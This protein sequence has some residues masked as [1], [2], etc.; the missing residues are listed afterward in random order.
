LKQKG[1]SSCLLLAAGLLISSCRPAGSSGRID[2]DQVQ[3]QVGTGG[4]RELGRWNRILVSARATGGTFQGEVEVSGISLDGDR[5][6]ET[7]RKRFEVSRE[8]Q[9]V[10]IPFLPRDW[11][12][13]EVSFHGAGILPERLKA[14]VEWPVTPKYR[15][16][17]VR[18]GPPTISSLAQ[19]AGTWLA[20]ENRDDLVLG[21]ISPRELPQNFLG[22]QVADLV[23]LDGTALAGADPD[24]LES[25]LRW[26]RRGGTIAAI[27]GP[28]WTGKLPRRVRELF[29]IASPLEPVA[30]PKKFSPTLAAKLGGPEGGTLYSMTPLPGARYLHPGI[31]LENRYGSGTAFLCSLAPRGE[32]LRKFPLEP[33]V[34]SGAWR[35]IVKRGA[36]LRV[37]A[38]PLGE[39]EG[40]AVQTLV[41]FSGFRFPPRSKVAIFILCYLG[42]GFLLAGAFF[43]RKKRLEWMYLFSLVLAVLAS[44]GIYRYGLLSSIKELSIDEVT[45][46]TVRPDSPVAE[47]ASFLGIASP[48]RRTMEGGVAGSFSE[49]A[50]PSQP[51]GVTRTFGMEATPTPLLPLDYVC[52]GNDIDLPRILLYP[53]ATRY[54]RIDHRADLGGTLSAALEE[55]AGRTRRIRISNSTRY[56]LD[57]FLLQGDQYSKSRTLDPGTV[58]ETLSLDILSVV[59]GGEPVP[60]RYPHGA[61]DQGEVVRR[62]RQALLRTLPRAPDT[63][64]LIACLQ[65]PLFPPGVVAPVRRS[66]GFL[67]LELDREEKEGE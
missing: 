15:I 25:L 31:L 3:I 51:V 29:G 65:E 12:E 1:I 62:M 17:L 8:E 63:A 33:A 39:M 66:L 52:S 4:L 67:V 45:V 14:P 57:V 60:F 35:D 10:E 34:L 20:L 5:L 16:L 2:P 61:L 37:A 64:Y 56:S 18:E 54:L 46:A 36:G 49:P 9:T 42:V 50:I 6:P 41:W 40:E 13:I 44:I 59:D 55:S 23:V 22:Y 26:V 43:A 27:P 47:A 11:N 32:L 7:F 58:A 38:N 24:R 28:D 30:D 48:D 21:S 53:N 19:A